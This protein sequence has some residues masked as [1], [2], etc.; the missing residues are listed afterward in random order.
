MCDIKSKFMFTSG[1]RKYNSIDKKYKCH[2]KGYYILAPPGS[3]KSYYIRHLDGEK[4]DWLDADI[5]CNA[6]NTCWHLNKKNPV[7]LRLNYLRN[8]YI[9]EQ[10]RALGYRIL[11]SLFWEDIKPD[12]I[13]MPDY[14]DHKKLFQKRNDI[15]L[16]FIKKIRSLILKL[17]KKKKVKVFKTI[18]EA[19]KYCERK[20]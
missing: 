2:K 3:G 15:N 9:I 6:C 5:L 4:K 13:V 8:E 18:P 19:I 16:T 11:G 1:K 17:A 10:S 14:K 20:I 12:A 7:E